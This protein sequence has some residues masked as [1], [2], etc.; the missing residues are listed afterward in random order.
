M[1]ETFELL[2]KSCEKCDLL[3]VHIQC[4]HLKKC[5]LKFKQL[6]LRNYISYFN[7]NLQDVLCEYSYTK[8]ES[9]V[10]IRTTM[11]KIQDF[12]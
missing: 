12:C 9:L 10:H 7:K 11:A 6:C 2:M 3:F 5:T 4:V 8:S 1:M